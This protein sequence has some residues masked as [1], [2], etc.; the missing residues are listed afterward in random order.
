M[1]KTFGVVFKMWIEY[2]IFMN[3][4]RQKEVIRHLRNWIQSLEE[5]GL[6]MGFAFNHYYNNP[7][8]P[9]SLRIRFEYENENNKNTVEDELQNEVRQL[10]PDYALQERAWIGTDPVLKAYEFG[11]RCTFLLMEKIEQGRIPETYIMDYIINEN[12]MFRGFRKIPLE[13]QFHFSH[14][15][16][17]SSGIHKRPNEQWLRLLALIESTGSTNPDQLCRWIRHQPALLFGRQ[18]G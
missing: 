16:M 1:K 8:E 12:Q 2:P 10:V 6:V 13:F 4:K 3:S 14:G 17:N 5:R 9:D 15:T 7:N 11:S 18:E